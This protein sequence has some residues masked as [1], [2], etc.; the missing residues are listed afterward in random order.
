MMIITGTTV[1]T[2]ALQPVGVERHYLIS[3]TF[4]NDQLS[5]CALYL[6]IAGAAA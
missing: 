3:S 6:C 1:L 5:L 4:V 2:E